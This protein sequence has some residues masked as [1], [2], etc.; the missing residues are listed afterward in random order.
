M[1]MH[2]FMAF[3]Y[4]SITCGSSF[5]LQLLKDGVGIGGVVDA[6]SIMGLLEDVILRSI[7]FLSG[8]RF[9]LT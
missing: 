2:A 7:L 1:L 8:N 6:L 9:N 5:T 4:M 3:L